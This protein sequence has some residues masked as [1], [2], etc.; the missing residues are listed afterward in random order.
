MLVSRDYYFFFWLPGSPPG[1]QYSCVKAMH[2]SVILHFV[3]TSASFFHVHLNL[4][5]QKQC[6]I[7][8]SAS[9]LD[10]GSGNDGAKSGWRHAHVAVSPFKIRYVGAFVNGRSRVKR[11]YRQPQ[12]RTKL[13][14]VVNLA[15]CSGWEVEP[16]R[17]SAFHPVGSSSRSRLRRFRLASFSSSSFVPSN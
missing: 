8:S 3:V 5:L 11:Q 14:A 15:R 12:Y 16:L 2:N 13:D 1:A 10:M 4:I 17:L 9:E 6:K 7:Q